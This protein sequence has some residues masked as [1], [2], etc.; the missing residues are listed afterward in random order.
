MSHALISQVSSVLVSKVMLENVPGHS[1]EHLSPLNHYGL[2]LL[3]MFFKRS[4]KIIPGTCLVQA[5]SKA[6]PGWITE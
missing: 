1:T 3:L 2:I 4:I 6:I 5:I